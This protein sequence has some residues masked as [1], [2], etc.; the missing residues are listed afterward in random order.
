[1]DWKTSC[2]CLPV[3][4]IIGDWFTGATA[5]DFNGTSA[6]FTVRR[7]NAIKTTVPMSATNGLIHLATPYGTAASLFNFS[8]P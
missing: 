6:P 5:V 4:E 1:M 3:V 2:L 8:I 7:N